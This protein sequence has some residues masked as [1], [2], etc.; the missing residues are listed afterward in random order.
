MEVV[1][2]LTLCYEQGLSY[3]AISTARSALSTFIVIDQ[4]PVGQHPIIGRLV[5][6]IFA[7]RPALP[8]VTVVWDTE[9]VLKYLKRLSPCHRLILPVLTWKLAVLTALLTGQRAQ[10]LHLMDI[11]NMTVS[12]SK[13]KFRFGDLLKQTRPGYQQCEIT[14]LAYPPDRRLCL[15]LLMQEYLKRVKPLRGAHTRLFITTQAPYKEAS[16]QT[17]SRWIKNTLVKAGLDMT[18]FSPH[19]TRSAATTKA[20]SGN[21]PL[22]TILKTAGWSRDSTFAKYYNK[23]FISEGVFADAVRN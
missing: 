19:S 22:M 3:S 20:N 12:K 17:I 15:V 8:K 21:I 14:V 10:S 23:P 9:I 1:N 18:I 13:I 7:S 11:R 16:K 5:K 2:F 6:G 4:V